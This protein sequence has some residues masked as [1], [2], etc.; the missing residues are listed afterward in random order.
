MSRQ[1]PDF[2]NSI[3]WNLVARANYQANE[4]APIANRLPPRNFLIEN[5]NVLIIGIDS[6]SARSYWRTGGWAV[7]IIPFL[8]SSTSTYVAAV[9]SYRKWLR[10]RV[11][12]LAVFPKISDTWALEI[13]FPFYFNDASVEIWRYD[14]RDLDEFSPLASIEA[15][16][17]SFL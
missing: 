1:F 12:T 3:E 5:S 9:H 17:D 7:Q 2:L 4:S 13:S 6:N 11:L 10:L 8:P 14:G 16:I 15:K